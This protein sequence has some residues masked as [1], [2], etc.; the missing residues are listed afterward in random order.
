[1]PI[2]ERQKKSLSSDG[3]GAGS[4]RSAGDRNSSAATQHNPSER[5]GDRKRGDRK[6][7]KSDVLT[8]L[9]LPKT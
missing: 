9:S 8:G 7:R 4:G 2:L 1:M 3:K 5:R 6:K